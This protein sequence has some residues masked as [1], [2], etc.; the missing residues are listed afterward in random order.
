MGTK[1]RPIY[2]T[3]W[4]EKVILLIK[5]HIMWDTNWVMWLVKPHTTPW[6]KVIANLA[7]LCAS[8]LA[9][10]PSKVKLQEK[11]ADPFMIHM[12]DGTGSK[13]VIRSIQPIK[14]FYLVRGIKPRP[15]LKSCFLND[16]RGD[17]HPTC[18]SMISCSFFFLYFLFLYFFSVFF[19]FVLCS[20]FFKFANFLFK[21][22]NIFQN[23]WTFLQIRH[24]FL[25]QWFFKNIWTFFQNW[26]NFSKFANC[27][28]K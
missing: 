12:C 8:K 14:P 13:P 26:W 3:F 18:F 16:A 7:N 11:G 28:S 5:L 17:N 21:C 9:S 19:F 2:F 20:F 27:F 23:P 1:T 15:H 24:H 10:R 22:I 6:A 25:N 4:G